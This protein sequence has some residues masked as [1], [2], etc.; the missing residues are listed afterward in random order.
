MKINPIG[1]QSYQQI[2]KRDEAV[3]P[4]TA[5]QEQ[6]ANV[7]IEP[8]NAVAKSPLALRAKAG[9]YADSLTTDE[10]RALEL[11][12]SRFKDPSRFSMN[13][14]AEAESSDA[15]LGQVIDVKI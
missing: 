13:N 4:N 12:F 14:R 15:G 10:R 7:T 6:P 8:K 11:L 5:Q 3:I 2:P 1:I 9:N